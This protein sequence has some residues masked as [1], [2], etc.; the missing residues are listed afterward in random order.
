VGCEVEVRILGPEDASPR[1]VEG[2]A[3]RTTTP[4]Q[5]QPE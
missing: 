3:P 2:Q 4:D 5:G 1:R